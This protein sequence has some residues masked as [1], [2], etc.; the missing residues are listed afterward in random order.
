M[1]A[2]GMLQHEL[3]MVR[4]QRDGLQAALD[5]SERE[6]QRLRERLAITDRAR[7]LA[8]ADLTAAEMHLDAAGLPIPSLPQLSDKTDAEWMDDLSIV[9]KSVA[10]LRRMGITGPDMRHVLAPI[11]D[12]VREWPARRE[13]LLSGGGDG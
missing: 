4:D 11:N 2:R 10:M 7:Q 9:F 5:A 12:N 6:C 3:Q 13:R 1:S 8:L